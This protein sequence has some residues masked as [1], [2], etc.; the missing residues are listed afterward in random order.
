M[1]LDE[2]LKG[3]NIA[4]ADWEQ[5]GCE[6]ST[7]QEIS[8]DYRT[9]QD[10]LKDVAEFYAK[11]IQK[12]EKVHSVRWRV[13]NEQ[14][15]LEKIVRKRI[16]RNPKYQTINKDNYFEIITDL[17]GIRALH[18][19][20]DDFRDIHTSILSTWSPAEVLAFVRDG[21]TST[22][23]LNALG[24]EIRTH[25][26]GYRSLHYVFSAKPISR[27]VNVELQV[28]TIFEEG[29]SE[30]DHTIR[31]PNFS[32]NTLVNYFLTIFNR[33]AGS[34]DEMGGFVK[35]LVSELDE[36]N[37]ALN[38]ASREKAEILEK[39]TLTLAELEEQR[40]QS[41]RS[42]QTI[43]KLKAELASLKRSS[44]TAEALASLGDLWKVLGKLDSPSS[45]SLAKALGDYP[46]RNALS[47]LSRTAA[48]APKGIDK[49]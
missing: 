9:R 41:Q 32:D 48:N 21:D 16:E 42:S 31:Y 49:K 1:T 45:N 7:L 24:L 23:Q 11:I 10:E 47:E 29:W 19:F 22:E 6:W 37:E 36:R 34:A 20:K 13:K 43:E 5:S 28:R 33:L 4:H 3:N 26:A 18:L 14:H 12:I 44:S 38:R 27:A 39:M 2:F 46:T 8:V 30:I 40:G 35:G 25:P 17:V 15:L